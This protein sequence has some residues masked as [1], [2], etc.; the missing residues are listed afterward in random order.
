MHCRRKYRHYSG[1]GHY[2]AL[3]HYRFISSVPTDFRRHNGPP[4]LLNRHHRGTTTVWIVHHHSGY[5]SREE[6]GHVRRETTTPKRTNK[7]NNT[8]ATLNGNARTVRVHTSITQTVLTFLSRVVSPPFFA[9]T[10]GIHS[11]RTPHSCNPCRHP[12]HPHKTPKIMSNALA[13]T[14]DLIHP[15]HT[16]SLESSRTSHCTRSPLPPRRRIAEA[17]FPLYRACIPSSSST[18]NTYYNRVERHIMPA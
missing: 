6:I 7:T 9:D 8:Y 13:S 18:Q 1:N 17:P 2:S 16:K 5:P 4:A 11:Y 14:P 10:Q 3:C 12:L 15:F